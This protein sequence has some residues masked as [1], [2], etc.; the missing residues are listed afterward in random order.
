MDAYPLFNKLSGTLAGRRFFGGAEIDL[1]LLAEKLSKLKKYEV[2]FWVGDYGQKNSEIFDNIKVRKFKYFE[3]H[4]KLSTIQNVYRKFMLIK[5]LLGMDEDIFITETASRLVGLLALFVKIL[6]RKILIF[7]LASDVNTDLSFYRSNRRFYFLYKF[8]IYHCNLIICQTNMQKTL[9][10]KNLNLNSIVITNALKIKNIMS[11]HVKNHILWVG[12]AIPL[13]RPELFIELA[14]RLPEEKFTMIMTGDSKTKKSIIKSLNGL[15]NVMLLDYV[16]FNSI[17]EYYDSA[18]LFVN[19]SEYEGFP[20]SFLQACLGKTP[21]LSFR[22]NPDEFITR[23]NIGIVCNDNINLAVEFI[24][25]LNR[26]KITIW[27]SNAYNY[28]MQNHNI[29]NIITQY[30]RAFEKLIIE[31]YGKI[32]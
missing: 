23:Y 15:N 20:N 29:D 11:F 19:T 28:I 25:N 3:N 6:R 31:K 14:Y 27:G 4:G 30:E 22:V 8:G 5:Q 10:K 16:P 1:Y 7:R 24:K 2:T 32:K 26:E 9:L 13:K 17:Q 18:K 12:R 21:I